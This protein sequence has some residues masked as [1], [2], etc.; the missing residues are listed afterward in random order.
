MYVLLGLCLEIVGRRQLYFDTGTH[1]SGICLYVTVVLLRLQTLYP[2]TPIGILA[3][4]VQDREERF[5]IRSGFHLYDVLAII[6]V[7]WWH[8][9]G[10]KSCCLPSAF[11]A[12]RLPLVV[13]RFCRVK[14]THR[15]HLASMST[16]TS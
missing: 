1:L 9:V 16:S 13:A 14:V 8:L 5:V 4:S 3:Q 7:L 15:M 10:C 12:Q 2:E 6:S 11:A